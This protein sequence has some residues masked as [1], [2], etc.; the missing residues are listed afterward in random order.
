MLETPAKTIM[1]D[2]GAKQC[3]WRST[4]VVQQVGGYLGHTGRG[5]DVLAM[6]ARDPKGDVR[7]VGFRAASSKAAL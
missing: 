7:N 2:T 3:S 4:S 5:A 1:I 6:A